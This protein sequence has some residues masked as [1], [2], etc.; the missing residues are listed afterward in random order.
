ML[1]P[2]TGDYTH[3]APSHR[4]V[5]TDPVYTRPTTMKL[6]FERTKD[7][8]SELYEEACFETNERTLELMLTRPGANS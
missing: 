2:V 7:Y 6:T 1:P 5:I 4:A 3:L 8:G